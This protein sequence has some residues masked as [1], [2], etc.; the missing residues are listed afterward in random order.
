MNLDEMFTRKDK[1]GNNLFCRNGN[2]ELKLKNEDDR[3][4]K[5][6][7]VYVG[8]D[9]GKIIYNKEVE[10]K[11]FYRNYYAWGI[12]YEVFRL[13]DAVIIRNKDTKQKYFIRTADI[14]KEF[15]HFKK[16]GFELQVFVHIDNWSAK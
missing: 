6:G 8:D 13:V 4:R 9:S 5:I 3:V 2:I 14:D 1:D 16:T 11:N 10:N 7:R 15:L 12:N